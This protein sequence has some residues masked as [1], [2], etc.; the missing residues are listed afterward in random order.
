MKNKNASLNRKGIF[1]LRNLIRVC[2]MQNNNYIFA[3]SKK[4][5]SPYEDAPDFKYNLP[6]IS[7]FHFADYAA[8]A[9]YCRYLAGKNFFLGKKHPAGHS[10]F[11]GR[12]EK[13]HRHYGQ[14]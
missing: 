5:F 13:L 8:G 2:L 14:S 10:Y 12:E 9:G 1:I 6:H 3:A 7:S 11:P 4:V